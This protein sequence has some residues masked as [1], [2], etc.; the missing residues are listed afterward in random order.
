MAPDFA[1]PGMGIDAVYNV[2]A[3][4]DNVVRFPFTTTTGRFSGMLD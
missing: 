3:T 1:V 2:V 4:F